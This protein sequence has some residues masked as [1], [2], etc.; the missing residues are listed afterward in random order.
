MRDIFNYFTTKHTSQRIRFSG[1]QNVL[2]LKKFGTHGMIKKRQIFTNALDRLKKE[3][4]YYVK[5]K[6]NVLEK[7]KKYNGSDEYELKLLNEML[8]E[9]EQTILSVESNIQEY[10]SKLEKLEKEEKHAEKSY[11]L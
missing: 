4:S 1:S 5:E 10:V 6:E 11:N 2:T 7:I 8:T 3:H 9:V